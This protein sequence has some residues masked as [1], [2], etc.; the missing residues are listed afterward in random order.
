MSYLAPD[1]E[2]ERQEISILKKLSAMDEAIT[3]AAYDPHSPISLKGVNRCHMLVRYSLEPEVTRDEQ[4]CRTVKIVSSTTKNHILWNADFVNKLYQ[5]PS[6]YPSYQAILRLLAAELIIGY[7]EKISSHEVSACLAVDIMIAYYS[8]NNNPEIFVLQDAPSGNCPQ[9]EL[10]RMLSHSELMAEVIKNWEEDN[11]A[12]WR[13]DQWNP[14][15]IKSEIDKIFKRAGQQMQQQGGQQGGQQG[16]QPSGQQQQAAQQ[17]QQAAQQ[18]QAAAQQASQAAQQAAQAAQQSTQNGNNSAAQQ[19]AQAAQTAQQVAQTAAQQ[20]QQAQQSGNQQ[21]AQQAAQQA[22][23]AASQAQAAAQNAQSASQAAQQAQ[24]SGNQ[25]A[26]QQSAQQAAQSAAQSAQQA[27][28]QAQSAASQAQQ[29]ANQAQQN[30]SSN[31]TQQNNNAAQQ[32]QAAAQQAQSAAQQAQSASQQAQQAAQQSST[33]GSS[34]A[35]QQAQN[36]AQQAAQAAQQAQQAAQQAQN[37]ANQSNQLNPGQ[38][39]CTGFGPGGGSQ[40]GQQGGQQGGSQ[41]GSHGGQQ[42]GSQGGQTGGQTGSIDGIEHSQSCPLLEDF[43]NDH[44]RRDKVALVDNKGNSTNVD[45]KGKEKVE[46]GISVERAEERSAKERARVGKGNLTGSPVCASG[47]DDI[48]RLEKTR[49]IPTFAGILEDFMTEKSA[50]GD[51]LEV[52]NWPD[53]SNPQY[54]KQ[55]ELYS[56][57]IANVLVAIDASGSMYNPDRVTPGLKLI[58][59]LAEGKLK[60]SLHSGIHQLNI[61]QWNGM[62][63]KD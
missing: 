55:L 37:A 8:A 59:G 6:P 46:N 25:Q 3:K 53:P 44:T 61:Q 60:L 9:R 45:H 30:A 28:Q 32:A 56:N 2:D 7:W 27:A 22:Q 62:T 39:G 48:I 54:Y 20:A 40:G 43:V 12:A 41:G 1:A 58:Q 21:A 26:A 33:T 5:E 15:T 50:V 10:N 14:Y 57:K 4:M 13:D 42:G 51:N 38:P 49:F 47:V 17:A 23:Q 16:S 18:A 11:Q 63:L 34:Q 19:A 24:Q 35:A 36:A 29:A 31:P 52:T